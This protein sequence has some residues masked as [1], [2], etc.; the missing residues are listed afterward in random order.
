MI[1]TLT[2]YMGSGKSSTGIQLASLLRCVFVDLDSY[3]EDKVGKSIADIFACEG[4]KAFRAME[5]E[6]LRDIVVMHSLTGSSVV[7]ALG[8]GTL[9][10]HALQD[11]IFG[12]TFCI[13]LRAD[14]QLLLR[15]VGSGQGRPLADSR[16]EQRLKE[17]ESVYSR[18]AMTVDTDELTPFQVAQLI[19]S[20]VTKKEA[21]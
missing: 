5:A 19:A 11:L 10:T 20:E 16:F 21:Q 6:A 3:I 17:R 14:V 1:V 12:E 15:R 2:G 9:M 13:W 7:I 4:E 8:G 18:A